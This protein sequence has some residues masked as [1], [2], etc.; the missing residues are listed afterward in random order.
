MN[1]E[2]EI[3]ITI[4][5]RKLTYPGRVMGVPK[6]EICSLSCKERYKVKEMLEKEA[7][8]LFWSRL[9]KIFSVM[10][11]RRGSFKKDKTLTGRY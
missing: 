3:L 4:K 5:R 10:T 11:K 9:S 7:A 2:Q 6:Y 8:E 1:K